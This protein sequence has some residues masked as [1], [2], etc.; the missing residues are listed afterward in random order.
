MTMN[1][2]GVAARLVLWTLVLLLALDNMGIDVTALVTG[3]GIG[4]MRERAERLGGHLIAQ[5]DGRGWLV[6]CLVPLE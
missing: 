4:G 5:R 3:L 1:V 2:L 6:E